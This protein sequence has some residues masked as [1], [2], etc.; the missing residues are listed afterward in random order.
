MRHK[1]MVSKRW[2]LKLRMQFGF[3]LGAEEGVSAV[4]LELLIF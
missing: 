3:P 4:K 2:G 1:A